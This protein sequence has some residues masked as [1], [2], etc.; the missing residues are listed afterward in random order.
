MTIMITMPGIGIEKTPEENILELIKRYN[1]FEGMEANTVNLA[2]INATYTTLMDY[3][4]YY[5]AWNFLSKHPLQEYTWY[6]PTKRAPWV[7]ECMNCQGSGR[8][9]Y[10]SDTFVKKCR[11]CDGT[12]YLVK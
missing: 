10:E 9:M 2:W 3:V 4:N 12:G 11:R 7:E 6:T 8:V 1:S 5:N